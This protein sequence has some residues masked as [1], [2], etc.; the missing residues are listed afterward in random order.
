MGDQEIRTKDYL[1]PTEIDKG[2][3]KRMGYFPDYLI[4]LGGVPI[5]VVEVKDPKISPEKGYREARL[6]ATEINKN[7]PATINPL[8][9]VLATNGLQ[10]YFSP[11]DSEKDLSIVAV[12]D[13]RKGTKDYEILIVSLERSKL[14]EHVNFIRN[15]LFPTKRYKPLLLIGGPIAKIHSCRIIHLPL[16]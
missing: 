3:G 7:Y 1:A 15:R 5:I 6:Y 16:N 9:Y 4:Y 2:A 8:K 13:L 11:W 10:L 14:A 12:N